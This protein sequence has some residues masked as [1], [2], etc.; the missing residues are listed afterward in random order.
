[1]LHRK[2][3]D[4]NRLMCNSARTALDSASRGTFAQSRRKGMLIRTADIDRSGPAAQLTG[5][6]NM[7][8]STFRTLLPALILVAAAVIPA[9]SHAVDARPT[10]KAGFDF[11]GDTLV[12]VVFTDGSTKSI[13]ANEGLYFGG[14]VSILSDSKDIET[15]VSLSYKFAGINASNGSVDRTRFPLEVLVFYRLPQFRLGG[16]L[17]YHL[18]PKLSGSGFA[19]GSLKYD[20]SAGYVLQADYLLQKITVGLRYTSLDY[21]L[22]GDSVKSNGA[23]ITFGISF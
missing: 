23:G 5:E 13:N 22:G 1:M 18:S 4:I 16:G 20:D 15:E 6:K 11:G 2:R 14:G 8:G 21:K 19:S 7:T 9:A 10:L 3:R 17:T 12:T